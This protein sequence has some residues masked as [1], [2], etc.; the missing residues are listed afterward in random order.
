M[1]SRRRPEC[2]ILAVVDRPK[3]DVAGKVPRAS[4]DPVERLGARLRA[5]R[6][7]SG[8]TLRQ[9]ARDLGLSPSFVSQVENGKSQPSVA[10]LYAI[11]QLLHVSVDELFRSDSLD[12]GEPPDTI[13]P[14]AKEAIATG[15]GGPQ[16]AAA[17]TRQGTQIK[18]RPSSHHGDALS[19]H[20]LQADR[21]RLVMGTG[22]VWEQLATNND[23]NLDFMEITYPPGSTSTNDSTML[24]HRG[25]EYGYLLTG[26]L[27][28]VLE[29]GSFTLHAGESMSLDSNR[30]HR[31]E[32]RRPTPTRGIWA[33]HHCD[34]PSDG[35]G[36][37]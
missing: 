30:P 20:L 11:A 4:D 26:E 17:A 1:V 36:S 33:V 6:T 10:T 21:P 25:T 29:S 8:L 32:N 22:V 5:A 7:R 27:E 37:G 31:F 19:S 24:R 23:R 3:G 2:P 14:Q 28:V 18:H 13:Q 15:P 16:S 34:M 12:T 35:A 9:M